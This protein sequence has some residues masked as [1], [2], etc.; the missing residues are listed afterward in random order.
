MLRITGGKERVLA[1]AERNGSRWGL[2]VPALHARKTAIYCALMRAGRVVLRP[3]VACLVER[4]RKDGLKL[5]VATT[6]SR[7]NVDVLFESTLGL[8]ALAE[9]NV[10]CC[11]EE[12]ARKQPDPAVYRLAVERLGID[13]TECVAFEDS[14]A[15]VVAARAAGVTTI[16]ATTSLC[17]ADHYL[18]GADLVLPD[19]GAMPAGSVGDAAAA[20]LPKPLAVMLRVC[21]GRS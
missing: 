2:D 10:I 13:G 15:G 19:L 17:T 12:V 16:I 18:D 21:R 8:G 3:G 7:A 14:E 5:A 9:F 6:T 20:G 11:G 1:F 4:A